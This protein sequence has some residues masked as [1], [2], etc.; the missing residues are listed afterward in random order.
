ALPWT[1][2]FPVSAALIGLG[3]SASVGLL[4]GLYPAR[5]ASKKSPIEAL[6]YE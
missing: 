1:F 2:S 3:V 5:Q 4:F 6:R